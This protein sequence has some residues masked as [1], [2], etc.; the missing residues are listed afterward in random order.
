MKKTVKGLCLVLFLLLAWGIIEPYTINVENEQVTIPN[1]PEEWD[2]KKIAVIGDFQIGMWMDNSWTIKRSIEKI[3][4]MKPQAVLLLGDYLYHPGNN[5]EKQMDKVVELLKP[6]QHAKIPT[7]SV[8]GNH[9]YGMSNLNDKYKEET[10]KLVENRLEQLGITVVKNETLQLNISKD[11]VTFGKR[12]DASLNL[13]GIGATWPNHADPDKVFDHLSKEDPRIVFMHN[14]AT[15][16]QLAAY[17]APLAIAGHTHGSQ[18]MIP[19]LSDW[20]YSN[21]LHYT[22]IYSSGWIEGHGQ[23]GNRLYVN[24]GIGFSNFPIR[25]NCPPEITVFELTRETRNR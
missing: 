22:G 24:P 9:D 16:D 20:F 14:P 21:I 10:A 13:V 3:I 12:T 1:L 25:I 4:K 6:L 5:G 15:Y 17:A 11:Q 18:V 2:G 23:R 19:V 8:L 7:F